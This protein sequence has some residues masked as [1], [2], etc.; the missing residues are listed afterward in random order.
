MSASAAVSEDKLTFVLPVMGAGGRTHGGHTW[1]SWLH[2]AG[3]GVVQAQGWG[4]HSDG[5]SQGQRGL[6]LCLLKE[7]V[8]DSQ[9]QGQRQTDDLLH[10]HADHPAEQRRRLLRRAAPFSPQL[11]L[12]DLNQVMRTSVPLSLILRNQQKNPSMES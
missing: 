8:L 7:D 11:F 4:R 6:H 12:Q 5:V 3:L 2:A 9:Q 1:G 10:V